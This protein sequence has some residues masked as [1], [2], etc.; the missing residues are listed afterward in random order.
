MKKAL[1][2]LLALTLSL[3]LCACGNTKE[4]EKGSTSDKVTTS[5][6]SSKQSTM[7]TSFDL[8]AT[9]D[10]IDKVK[11]T[12]IPANSSMGI[13]S[14][15]ELDDATKDKI[16][17]EFLKNLGLESSSYEGLEIGVEFND[18]MV[19]TI[20][21]NL[22]TADKDILQKLGMN[23]DGYDMSLKRAVKDMESS[24]YTCE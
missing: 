19:I 18:N 12:V 9:N 22:K 6:C 21:A 14:F 23:F 17:Q 5:T 24:G 4:T 11:M 13:T 10:E 20:D 3:T 15:T 2:L 16:K 8:S 7:E 1:T